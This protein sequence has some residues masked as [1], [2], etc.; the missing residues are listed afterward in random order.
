[1]T[2]D[3]RDESVS[4]SLRELE[5]LEQERKADEERVA[6]RAREEEAARLA[7][8]R[9]RH[10][11]A[12]QR[13]R[14]ARQRQAEDELARRE[15]MQRALVEQARLEVEARTRAEEAERERRH[16]VELARLRSAHGDDRGTTPRVVGAG[17]VGAL[18]AGA[19]AAA[20]H[21][22]VV[23]PD[24]ARKDAALEVCT[25]SERAA[26]GEAATRRSDLDVLRRENDALSAKLGRLEAEFASPQ[27]TA[28]V[29]RAVSP[30]P[31]GGTWPTG[32]SKK[33]EPSKKEPC[34]P[35]DP[36]CFSI[37]GRSR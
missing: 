15:A 17:I 27:P 21:A 35:R 1:M 29:V 22:A 24:R 7:D 13:Q 4:F 32:L 6:A 9:D 37:D 30:P 16:E 14:D 31:K 5:K 11:Q 12:E 3:R 26:S 23:S 33:I 19:L 2:E 34:L 20:W 18:V 25:A 10:A 28:H 36:M 8:E